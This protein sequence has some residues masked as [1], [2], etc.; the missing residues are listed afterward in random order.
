VLSIVSRAISFA[1]VTAEGADADGAWC[2]QRTI[3]NNPANIAKHNKTSVRRPGDGAR[4]NMAK[5]EIWPEARD[6]SGKYPIGSKNS[7]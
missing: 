4:F 1:F 2:R 7:V 5:V 6:A 3:K